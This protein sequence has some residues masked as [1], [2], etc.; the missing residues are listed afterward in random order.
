LLTW[1]KPPEEPSAGKPLARICEGKAEWLS[2]S[3]LLTRYAVLFVM[4]TAFGA[5]LSHAIAGKGESSGGQSEIPL[6][7]GQFST[8]L[9]GSFAIC[10]NPTTFAEESCSTKGTLAVPLSLL[11]NGSVVGDHEGKSCTTFTE[12][13]SDLPVDASPPFVTTNAHSVGK[14]L[15][16]NSATG[17]GDASFTGY[18]GGKCDGASF[19]STGATK[20]S[21]GTFHFVVTNGGNRFD[22]LIMK[23]TNPIGSIGDFSLSGTALRQTSSGS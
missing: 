2:Y 3:T 9:Q 6:P 21:S 10:L 16:Y 7:A 5:V 23:L 12:V 11:D 8:T 22:D 13:D 17:T 14:L 4:L 19:D 20:V 18:T 15:N 1:G